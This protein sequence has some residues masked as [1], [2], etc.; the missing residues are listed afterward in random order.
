MHGYQ[1]D[2]KNVATPRAHHV[3]VGQRAP[4]SPPHTARLHRLDPQPVGEQHAEDGDALVIV[5]ARHRA[6][7]IAGHDSNEAGG[8]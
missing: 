8:Y 2:E 3:E 6:T 7:Y 4:C 5:A 1:I